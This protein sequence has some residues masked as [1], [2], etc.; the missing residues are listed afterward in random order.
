MD[1]RQEKTRAA[2]FQAFM[3]LLQEKDYAHITVREILD[4]A[5]V[6][7]STFYAHFSDKDALLEA[8]CTQLFDHALSAAVHHNHSHSGK[9]AEP[10]LL[11]L[12]YHLQEDD[13]GM[14]ALLAKDTSGTALRYFSR[15]VEQLIAETG[16]VRRTPEGVSSAYAIHFVARSYVDAADQWLLGGAVDAPE[17]VYRAWWAMVAP[18][19]SPGKNSSPT[20]PPAT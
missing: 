2:I 3:G 11:H 15:G 5:N 20:P 19:I 17:D 1:R 7:R 13:R 9:E 12:L 6:G 18:A 8:L 16:I 10:P 14:R 4:A